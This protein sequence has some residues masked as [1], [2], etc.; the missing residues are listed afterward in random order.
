[1]RSNGRIPDCSRTD[2][3]AFTAEAG[4]GS[5]AG[6]PTSGPEKGRLKAAFR[7]K[8]EA[9]GSTLESGALRSKACATM[10][11]GELRR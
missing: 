7:A 5:T 3:A 10:L 6:I 9:V 11:F 2:I 4:K 8:L 1:M